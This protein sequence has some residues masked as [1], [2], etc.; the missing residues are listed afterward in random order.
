[1]DDEERRNETIIIYTNIQAREPSL[2]MS[3][4]K[5]SSPSSLLA[6]ATDSTM[7]LTSLLLATCTSKRT[8]SSKRAKEKWPERGSPPLGKKIGTIDLTTPSEYE[9]TPLRISHHSIQKLP[10]M[11]APLS[12]RMLSAPLPLS[13]ERAKRKRE[14]KRSQASPNKLKQDQSARATIVARVLNSGNNVLHGRDSAAVT[15]DHQQPQ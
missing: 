13:V 5:Y 9:K 7:P 3:Y 11:C 2:S 4:S 1:M 14:R 12:S 10:E 15:A 6:Q 8:S